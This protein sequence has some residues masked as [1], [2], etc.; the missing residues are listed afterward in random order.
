MDL[1]PYDMITRRVDLKDEAYKLYIR[2]KIE[3]QIPNSFSRPSDASQ[4]S[5]MFQSKKQQGLSKSE[6][7]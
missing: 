2:M 1:I 4:K 7:R 6:W 3:R 5:A